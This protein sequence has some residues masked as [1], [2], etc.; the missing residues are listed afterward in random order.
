MRVSTMSTK[1]EP[2][3]TVSDLE[4]LPHDGNQYELFERELFVSRAPTLSHQRTLGNVYAILRAYPLTP[5]HW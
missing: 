2:I 1:A 5:C 3:L 4:A